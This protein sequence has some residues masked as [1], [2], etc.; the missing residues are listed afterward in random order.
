MRHATQ[1]KQENAVN[2]ATAGFIRSIKMLHPH[3]VSHSKTGDRSHANE[4]T[5]IGSFVLNHATSST[6]VLGS[7]ATLFILF[8]NT[9]NVFI[10]LGLRS[11][12]LY[13]QEVIGIHHYPQEIL[14]SLS[15]VPV[16]Q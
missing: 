11:L 6:E 9:G 16:A 5:S 2:V 7:N 15:S 13:K 10:N 4:F 8:N 3:D 14:N 12:L 1:D